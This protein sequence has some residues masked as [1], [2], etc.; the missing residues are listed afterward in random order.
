MLTKSTQK[1]FKLK[2]E[3]IKTYYGDDFLKLPCSK[4]ELRQDNPFCTTKNYQYWSLEL[5]SNEGKAL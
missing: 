2:N 5:K 3:A 1:L 4:F